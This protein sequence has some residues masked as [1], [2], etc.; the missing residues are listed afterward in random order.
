[1]ERDAGLEDDSRP[2]RIA[3]SGIT[4][5]FP[6]VIANRDV[7]LAIRAGEVHVLLGENGA[8]KS[9][10][11]AVLSGMQQPDAG[12]IEIEGRE[13]RIHSP[14]DAL[15]LGIGTV[16]QHLTLVPT[17]SVLENLMLGGAWYEAQDLAGTQAR[18][19]ELAA[20]LGIK[21]EAEAR[22]GHLSLGQQQQ[23]EIIKAL[24]RGE[25]V[26]ILD[27]PTSMLT[28]QGVQDLGRMIARLK[29]SGVAVVLVT[30]KLAEAYQFGDRVTVLRLGEVVG[31]IAP[32]EMAALDEATA[33]RRIVELMFGRRAG[34]DANGAA[35]ARPSARPEPTAQPVLELSGV[36]VAGQADEVSLE[37]VS[38]SVRPGEIFGIAGVDG[39]GQKLLAEAIAGQRS[40]NAGEIRL[41]GQSIARLSIAERQALGLRYGTDDRLGEGT[42]GELP[43]SLNLFL[44]RIGEAPFWRAGLIDP[45]KISGA[46]EALVADF[47]VRT[48]S[49]ATPV[50]KL[51]G[52][53]IQKALLARE[54]TL[55]PKFVV[56]NKPT[57]GLDVANASATHERIREQ[58]E[59]GVAAIVISTEL[60]ELLGLCDRIGVMFRGRLQGVVESAP[61]AEAKIGALMIGGQAA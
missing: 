51:S 9:T 46:A 40:I 11:I 24:W 21:V 37:D 2:L 27:E 18:L 53:N 54:L 3:L 48:P 19:A 60:D 49:V 8:G 43:V 1:M 15:D 26:L 61:D 59:A 17:L 28:P 34:E 6:G 20:L 4:K 5:R 7:D 13:A 33:T 32:A 16:Y 57:Y 47:D 23:V 58:A 29:R 12:R 41:L 56:Y 25:Q 55:T 30:H 38:L 45:E 44:K 52:G 50:A 14:R 42:V 39:N 22:V 35:P 10:L 31:E 36:S